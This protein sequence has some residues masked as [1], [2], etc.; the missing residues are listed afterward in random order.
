[1]SVVSKAGTLGTISFQPLTGYSRSTS[2]FFFPPNSGSSRCQSRWL[3]QRGIGTWAEGPLLP[4]CFLGGLFWLVPSLICSLAGCGGASGGNN[5]DRCV[6]ATPCS[7]QLW[8]T[9]PWASSCRWVRPTAVLVYSVHVVK[10]YTHGGWGW[11]P[12]QRG[13]RHAAASVLGP[14]CSKGSALGRGWRAEATQKA[15]V[16]RKEAANRKILNGI[17]VGLHS[18]C[19]S[20]CWEGI[21]ELVINMVKER[22]AYSLFPCYCFP[23][24]SWKII[25]QKRN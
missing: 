1:M 17:P 14:P 20:W 25:G 10:P 13:G 15:G 12:K 11:T 23:A 2:L 19:W 22:A 18:V 16:Q 7:R 24:A 4:F 5:W 8:S 9:G 21:Y 3:A 6:W